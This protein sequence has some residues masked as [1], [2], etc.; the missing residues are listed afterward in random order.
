MPAEA[1]NAD[2]ISSD[3]WSWWEARRLRYN[4]GLAVAGWA[5]WGLFVLEVLIA[6]P[7][8][9]GRF[10]LDLSLSMTLGQGLAFL[11]IM[12][13]ANLCYLLGAASEMVVKPVDAAG[14]R[15]R[16]W[17]LGFWFSVALPFFYPALIATGILAS[18]GL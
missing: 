13:I 16:M 15:K 12:A 18:A 3:A 11:V 7:I 1:L 6:K 9:L 2:P 8:L 5:A 4:I 17:G 14:Y 10:S